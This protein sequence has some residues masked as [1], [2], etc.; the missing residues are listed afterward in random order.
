MLPADSLASRFARLQAAARGDA[1]PEPA[2]R[3]RRLEALDRLLLDN[4]P[5]L[6]DAVRR[7]FGHR[8]PA[9]TRLLELFP[10]HE[11][12]R[13][14]RRHLRRWL[15]P[16]ARSVSLWFQ[17]GRA[18]V[19]H[20]PL[21]AVGIV[22]PWNYPVFLAAA[23]LAAALAAGN[24][25]LVKMSEI[26]PATAAL[27]AELVGRYFADDEV[28]VVEGGVSVAREF[29]QLP[30][31]HLLF[32]GS[33]P[34]GREVM[35]AA[36]GNLTPVT[37]ELGGKSPAIIGPGLAGSGHFTRAVERILVG[38]C[39]NAGQ[40]CIAPDYVLLPAGQEEAFIAAAQ[41]VVSSC[42]PQI[43]R[44][45]DYATIVDQR[46]Y[47]RLC[48]YLDE[49]RAA[50]ARIIDL[51]PA[52]VADPLRRSLSPV[53][54][55]EAA[56]HLRVM[57]EEIFGPLLPVLPYRDLEAAIRYVNQ[58][59]RPLA[60]YYFDQEGANIERVLDQTVSGGVTVN[61]TILH[62]AQDDL[63]FGGVGPSGMGGYHGFAGFETFSVR[64]AVFRQS[65]LS[66]IGL[67]K[68]PY[69][70]LFDRL[71]RILLR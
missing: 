48:A 51:A 4:E 34:V 61:D 63:P 47:D 28:S 57:Q 56:D 37:L 65:R 54:L 8:P 69:G 22:V 70:A 66:A 36:A 50:G 20:Q 25:V 71:T 55:L 40:T 15:R 11:A 53:V 42:Y 2:V 24:R 29:S 62:I 9:E 14:A 52:A 23:P 33:T 45:P 59:P 41:R 19:R 39:L 21:G 18:E 7:D 58:R 13:H 60:L 31:D 43:E 67:F 17:P 10:S 46:Q 3:L 35:R 26:T 68:P 32:T 27:F 38:K 1:N 64:K 30:F 6:A 44:N 16:Q 12:I 5:A 49:A